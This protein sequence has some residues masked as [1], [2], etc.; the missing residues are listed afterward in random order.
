MTV[1]RRE[2]TELKFLSHE[3]ANVLCIIEGH[4]S[5]IVSQS[6]DAS[7]IPLAAHI[8]DASARLRHIIDGMLELDG[9]QPVNYAH[10]RLDLC[11]FLTPLIEELRSLTRTHTLKYQPAV[12]SLELSIDPTR[13]AQVITN[14]V[15][16][17]VKYSPEESE[18]T[19]SIATEDD[20][21]IITVSDNGPGIPEEFHDKL[22]EKFSRLT[23]AGDGLGIGLYLSRQIAQEHGG[24]L[25]FFVTDKNNFRITLPR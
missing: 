21:A 23:T 7:I 13:I 1:I 2:P 25:D 24:D 19:V 3:I 18:I 6:A 4:A 20:F 22:F 15:L 14:L 8:L 10:V 5:K 12:A 9:S 11:N 16:N 17:A